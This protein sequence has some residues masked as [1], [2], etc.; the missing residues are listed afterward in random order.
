MPIPSD[1]TDYADDL[2][3][4]WGAGDEARM[5]HLATPEVIAVLKQHAPK[6]GPNW[7]HT[8]QDAGAGSS[9]VTY[10]NSADKS[11]LQVRIQNETAGQGEPH[12]V[13]EAKFTK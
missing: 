6:C 4:A 9:Y 7:E 11:V 2:V 1:A 12:A 8:V 10:T 5:N 13:V 3:R